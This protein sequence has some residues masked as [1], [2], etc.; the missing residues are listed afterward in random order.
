M[1]CG[2]AAIIGAPNAGKS[3]L[4]NALVGSKVAI[5]SPK[6]QTTRMN[7]RGVALKGEAQIVLVDTPGIF[8][9]RRRLDRAMVN[10]A[11]AGAADADAVVLLVDAPDLAGN[12]QG[13][14]ARD[15]GAIIESLKAANR[16][17]ALALNKIDAMKREELLPLAEKLNAAGVFEQV[18]MISA[19]S[20]DGLNDLAEWCAGKM[21]EGPWLYPA[22]QSA[23][24]P[25]RLLASEI[26]RE[27][28]YLRLH[29]ELPYAS[30]VET[31]KWEERKDG[32]VKIDQIVYVQRDGQ[33]AIALGKGGATIKV[34]G[35]AARKEMEQ[36]F[37]RRVHLFLFVKVREDWAETRAHY[38]EMGLE[39]PEE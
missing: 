35:E 9:P 14:A 21:P 27:K 2:F 22:D 38:R 33:K 8:K 39:F 34:I 17:A 28:I 20:G 36:I 32:S 6:V 1:R 25:S 37:G 24:I 29:D 30:A 31:E 18:F 19:L 16:R 23:D 11:W 13:H 26:T 4:V 10:A 5:V 12:P 7:V 15:S 3:T